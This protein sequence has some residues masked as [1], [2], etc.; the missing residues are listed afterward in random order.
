MTLLHGQEEAA[1]A[2][3]G[4]TGVEQR[5]EARPGVVSGGWR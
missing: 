1:F 2:D 5:P 3:A 4:Y